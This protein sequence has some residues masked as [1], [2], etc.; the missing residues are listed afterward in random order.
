MFFPNAHQVVITGGA[1]TDV[2]GD[3]RVRDDHSNSIQI[4]EQGI[5]SPSASRQEPD[6]M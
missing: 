5:S 6:N 3:I 2:G 4:A 1:F